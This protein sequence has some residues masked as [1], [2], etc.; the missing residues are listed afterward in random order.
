MGL[1]PGM[2][3]RLAVTVSVLAAVSAGVGRVR[4][5]GIVRFPR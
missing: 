2:G 4:Q 5:L 1:S 3:Q